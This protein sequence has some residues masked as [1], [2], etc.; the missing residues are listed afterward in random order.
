IALME[1][2]GFKASDFARLHPAGSLGKKLYLKVGD[3]MHKGRENP[4][5]SEKKTV[6][7]TLHVMTR[8]RLGAAHI[9]DSKGELVGFFTDGDL[10]RKLQKGANI[11]DRKISEVM[12]KNP[13]TITPDK[14]LHEAAEI[15]RKGGFDN[16]PVVNGDGKPIGILDERDLL[17]EGVV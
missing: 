1:K 16:I 2:R 10:R 11:L 4:V 3:L 5:V 13:T 14:T 7:Q 17:A 6:R 12:T 9:V 15:L 8:T